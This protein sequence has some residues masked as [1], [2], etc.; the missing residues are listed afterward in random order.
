MEKLI[1][2]SD[3][4]QLDIEFITAFISKTYWAKDRTSQMMQICIDHSLN[5]GVYLNKK[6]IG[7]ARVVTDYV[8]FAYIMDVFIDE[9]HQGKGF[10]KELMQFI[11]TDESLK[12]VKVWR[13]AT[14]D[15]HELYRKFGFTELSKPENMMELMK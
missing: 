15:A 5:F 3:K 13:L 4:N 2:T 1:I 14:A 6:Q 7:Y 10:S 8:Q 12:A 11:L 9:A